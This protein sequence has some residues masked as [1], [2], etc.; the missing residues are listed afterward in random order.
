MAKPPRIA[1]DPRFHRTLFGSLTE[2][3]EEMPPALIYVENNNCIA[4][5]DLLSHDYK[6]V[7]DAM[8]AE[9]RSHG[10]S[11][12]S[13]PVAFMV[14]QTLELTHKSLLEETIRAG[15]A[16][17]LKLLNTHKLDAIWELSRDWLLQ[18][19]FPIDNDQRFAVAEWFTRN[20]SA[21]DPSGDLFR[22]ANSKVEAYGRQKTYDRV[23]LYFG[24]LVTYFDKTFACLSHWSVVVAAAQ[25]K[26]AGEESNAE[27][28]PDDY[29]KVS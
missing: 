5:Y 4:G 17:P 15:N 13:A 10:L 11:N 25:A 29:P 22:F 6:M 12:W 27:W 21:V 7:T 19:S 16:D 2:F 9:Y 8:I 20:F 28:D 26:A 23:G 18:N 3:N 1:D 24:T 14:R